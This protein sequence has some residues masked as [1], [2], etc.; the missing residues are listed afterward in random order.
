MTLGASG[1]FY[2]SSKIMVTVFAKL[3]ELCNNEVHG[4]LLCGIESPADAMQ[5]AYVWREGLTRRIDVVKQ[6]PVSS[7]LSQRQMGRV[8]QVVAGIVRIPNIHR[9]TSAK[10]GAAVARSSR[11]RRMKSDSAVGCVGRKG[12]LS[13]L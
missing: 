4:I 10:S 1:E 6:K 7:V 11:R 12:L 9:E 5:S 13:S 3:E 2:I 8:A